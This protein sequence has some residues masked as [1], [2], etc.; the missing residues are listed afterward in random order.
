MPATQVF[1]LR[2]SLSCLSLPA[3]ASIGVCWILTAARSER[4]HRLLEIVLPKRTLLVDYQVHSVSTFREHVMLKRRWSEIGIHNVTRLIVKLGDPL[5][6]LHTVGNGGR[7]EDVANGMGQQ[8]DGF[9]PHDSSVCVDRSLVLVSLIKVGSW[10][11]ELTLVTHVMDLI[12]D[13]PSNL[14]HNFRTSVKHGP[15]D[16]STGG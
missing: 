8:D 15:Q 7:K 11:R 6:E 14:S 12:K 3:L 1:T 13:D 10:T 16:L 9:L 5:G 2:F 4:P